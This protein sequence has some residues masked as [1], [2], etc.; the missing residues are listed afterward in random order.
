MLITNPELIETMQVWP[1]ISKVVSVLH[2]QEQYE[3][4]VAFLDELIDIIGGQEEH[5]LASLL[6]TIGAHIEVYE[7][8]HM[9]EPIGD[10]ISSLK[11]LMAEHQVRKDDLPEI[12][13]E[14]TV[15]AVLNGKHPL[16]VNQIRAL[17][18]RFHV[19]AS[20]FL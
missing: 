5:P 8:N 18:T 14:S 6:D 12:G 2:T 17:G 20:V 19:S 4:A 10:P 7:N 13:S 1:T 9:R 3:R 11:L 15:T 16:N